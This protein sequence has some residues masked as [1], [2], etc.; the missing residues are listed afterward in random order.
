[1]KGMKSIV[2]VSLVGMALLRASQSQAPG[3]LDFVQEYRALRASLEA[4][5]Q[6][7][8]LL[9][10]NVRFVQGTGNSYG[11]Y[12]PRP[13]AAFRAGEPI[14]LYLEPVGY[15]LKK[16][17][18]GLYEFGFSA[19][20]TVKDAA[21]KVLGGQTGFADLNFRSWNFNTEV[22]LTFTY[23]F[24]GLKK[25]SYKVVT[26]VHDKFSDKRATVEQAFTIL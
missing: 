19:D 8:P 22:A 21:G 10:N 13:T 14:Y 11:I 25:G 7:A 12:D 24:S 16:N 20:F 5:W 9:L 18:T 26:V 17:P 23:R 2:M 1:M 6:R 15:T 4:F 3:G